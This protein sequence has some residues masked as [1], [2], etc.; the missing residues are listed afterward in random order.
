MAAAGLLVCSTHCCHNR[1]KRRW[2]DTDKRFRHHRTIT[3]WQELMNKETETISDAPS[4]FP[5]P[6]AAHSHGPELSEL[7]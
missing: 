6:S 3:S 2:Y 4:P 5:R 1:C 7:L